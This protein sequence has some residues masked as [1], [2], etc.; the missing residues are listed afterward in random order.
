[1]QGSYY[2]KKAWD[3]KPLPRW[4]EARALLPEP[5]LDQAPVAIT[6][7]DNAWQSCIE[8]LR[9]PTPSNGFVSNHLFVPFNDCIFAHD[10]AVMTLYA[11]YGKRSFEAAASFDNFYARQHETGEICR[12]IRCST[13]EDFWKKVP[14]DPVKVHLTLADREKGYLW[15]RPS[16]GT[17]PP[18]HVELDGLNDPCALLWGE[19]AC[20]AVTADTGRLRRILEPQKRWYEAFNVYLRDTNGLYITDWASADNHPR[21][22]FL[23]YGIDVACQVVLFARLL[24]RLCRICKDREARPY[25]READAISRRIRE[26]MWDDE[27][28][29]FFDLDRSDKRMSIM[30]VAGFWPLLAGVADRR[31]A[32]ALVGHLHNPKEFDRPVLVPTLA[33][34]EPAYT[35]LGSYYLG[36]V[37]PFTNVV[38]IEGL[39]MYGFD[40]EAQRVAMNFWDASVEVFK[41][42]GKFWEYLQPEAKKPGRT[43]GEEGWNSRAFTGWGAWAPISLLLEYAIG[44]RVDAPRNTLTWNISTTGRCGCR[45]FAFGDVVT[46]LV[47]ETRRD[48]TEEP[49]ITVSANRPYDLVVRWGRGKRKRVRVTP[50]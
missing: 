20:Y 11:R 27:R 19:L 28:G 30:S 7:Y 26:L 31:Q 13:G 38:V 42:T 22:D 21:N 50:S 33:A 43:I 18:G 37:W 32:A 35:G 25:E 8:D 45:R 47:A 12:E 15:T 5:I 9:S 10:T 24:A 34:C 2:S 41:D 17:H 49:R 23:G 14:A 4:E 36:G 44:L 39:E 29:F 6:A 1:M 48:T 16:V 3:G 40:Q 46:D